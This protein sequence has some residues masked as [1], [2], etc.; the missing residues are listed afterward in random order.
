[1][2]K[3]RWKKLD[4]G[5]AISVDGAESSA[6]ARRAGLTQADE[7]AST[8]RTPFDKAADD[9][10]ALLDELAGTSTPAADAV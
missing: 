9:L 10:R 7:A 8:S 6:F 2:L 5:H 3:S 4:D 1:M